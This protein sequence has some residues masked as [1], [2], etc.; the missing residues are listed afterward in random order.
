MDEFLANVEKYRDQ[1]YRFALRNVWDSSM[2][3]DVFASSVAAAYE[4][5]HKFT[6]GTNF[7]AWLFKIF[8]NKCFVANRET[9]RSPVSLD[10]VASDW[11]AVEDAPGYGDI[12]NDPSDFLEQCGDEV[13]R[14]F[15]RLSSSQRACI[16]LKDV[17]H[18][19]YKEIAEILGIPMATVMTH[20][21]RGRALL[22]KELLEYAQGMGFVRCI[23]KALRRLEVFSNRRA[24]EAK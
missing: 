18:F 1:L 17:E 16:L 20:L 2:V 14:A 12:L 4:N 23:P 5:R 24:K 13:Y 9:K 10:S 11:A 22:R 19:S 3:D 15:R 6:P 21:S 8:V 7:R